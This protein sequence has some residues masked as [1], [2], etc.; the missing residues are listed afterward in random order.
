M[1]C[2]C[3]MYCRTLGAAALL[4][5]GSSPSSNRHL[6]NS[7]TCVAT[8]RNCLSRQS[9]HSN[10][11]SGKM[12]QF[13][14]EHV[15]DAKC[16]TLKVLEFKCKFRYLSSHRYFANL[17]QN[18]AQRPSTTH[19][20]SAGGR[21]TAVAMPNGT[22]CVLQ[23]SVHSAHPRQSRRFDPTLF[24]AWLGPTAVPV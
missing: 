6:G 16:L 3:I 4:H 1:Y 20:R 17:G 15:V 5:I 13:E 2:S 10:H 9:R 24:T 23:S 7:H 11:L 14:R 8:G 19:A 18:R 12:W 22:G 21:I